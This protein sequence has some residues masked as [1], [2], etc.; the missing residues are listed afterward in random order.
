MDP[1]VYNGKCKLMLYQTSFNL[2]R[3]I[4]VNEITLETV[5][6]LNQ[7]T[8]TRRLIKFEI[9]RDKHSRIGLLALTCDYSKSNAI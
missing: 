3:A 8:C 1:G 7:I 9:L 6:I 5:T 4:S 2:H